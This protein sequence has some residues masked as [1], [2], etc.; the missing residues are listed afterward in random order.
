MEKVY[1]LSDAMAFFLNNSKGSVECIYKGESAVVNS[2]VAAEMF[3]VGAGEST[4]EGTGFDV[5]L[6][7][8]DDRDWLD[9]KRKE[10]YWTTRLG[11]VIEDPDCVNELAKE[12]VEAMNRY[13]S[14]TIEKFKSL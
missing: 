9:A 12:I 13:G 11:F 7:I 10:V 4:D 6:D 3:F 8:E 5:F 2:Y 1:N 14:M